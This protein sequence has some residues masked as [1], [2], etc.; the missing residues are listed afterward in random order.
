MTKLSHFRARRRSAAEK[1][2]L[3]PLQ[4]EIGSVDRLSRRKY[5]QEFN[6]AYPRYERIIPKSELFRFCAQAGTLLISDF[7]ALDTC[8]FF[9]CEVLEELAQSQA[10]P[11]VLLLEAVFTRDQ[12][13]VDEW[14]AG[15]ISDGELKSRLRFVLEWGYEWEPFL[16]TLKVARDLDIPIIGADCPPRGSLRRISRRDRHAAE[17]AARVRRAMPDALIVVFF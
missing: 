1:R 14:Q 3:L 16:H 10:R 12:H 17:I 15:R 7:H 4:R 5:L 13:I 11:L 8:Q 6:Q 2:L 9:L